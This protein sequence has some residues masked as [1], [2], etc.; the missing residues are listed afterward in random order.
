[1]GTGRTDLGSAFCFFLGDKLKLAIDGKLIHGPNP[2]DNFGKA[3]GL[4][5]FGAR[6][7]VRMASKSVTKIVLYL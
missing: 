4:L 3:K 2:A 5:G 6:N 7:T 1:M